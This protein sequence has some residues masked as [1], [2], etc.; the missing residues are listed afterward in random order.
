MSGGISL[1]N[2]SCLPLHVISTALATTLINSFLLVQPGSVLL[3]ALRHVLLILCLGAS[4]LPGS[5][6]SAGNC[7][8]P[9]HLQ[10]ENTIRECR[11]VVTLQ[12]C[13]T[14]SVCKPLNNCL[15]SHSL[16]REAVIISFLSLF[17]EWEVKDKIC[18]LTLLHSLFCHWWKVECFFTIWPQKLRYN[19]IKAGIIN[20]L[21]LAAIFQ[22]FFHC[23]KEK[24]LHGL[25]WSSVFYS[26]I[27][28]SYK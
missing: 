26:V 2:F 18:L 6:V 13:W 21:E 9:T 28:D 1:L 19:N 17:Q 11:R 20:R 14:N 3:K 23:S 27:T 16:R 8:T 15:S 4:P 12:L 25:S 5:R 24:W 10:S 22:F 7:S